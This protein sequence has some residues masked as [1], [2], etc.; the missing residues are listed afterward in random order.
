[1]ECYEGR[2]AENG[3]LD[4]DD[5]QLRTKL[6]LQNEEVRKKLAERFKY[7]MVDEYQDTNLVQYDILRPLITNYTTGNLFV[8]GDDKQSIYGFRGA[9]VEVFNR[10]RDEISGSQSDGK[11][12]LWGEEVTSDVEERRGRII[13]SESF[14]LLT[15]LVAFVNFVFKQV[16]GERISRYEVEYSPLVKARRTD[17]SGKIEM[18]LLPNDGKDPED[19]QEEM[20]ARR[21]VKLVESGQIVWKEG[22]TEDEVPQPIQF[23]DVAILL[24]KRKHL[25]SIEGAL[26]KHRIPY[27]ISGGVGFYQTQEVYDFFNYFQFLLNRHNDVA[28]AGIL[29]SPFFGISDAG[30][31][32]V[33]LVEQEDADMWSKAQHYAEKPEASTRIRFAVATLRKDLELAGRISIPSLIDRILLQTGWLGTVAGGMRGELNVANLD[34]LLDI[35]REFEGKGFNNLFDFAE[36]L[37]LLISDEEREGQATVDTSGRAV[38]IMTIHA[39][40]GLEFPVVILPY[41]EGNFRYDAAPYLDT[42]LGLGF[43]LPDPEDDTKTVRPLIAKLIKLAGKNRTEAE[44]KRVFYVGATRARDMLILAGNFDPKNSKPSYLRWTMDSL[45]LSQMP[46]T[47]KIKRES[48]TK[49]WTM[50]ETGHE[51]KEVNHA[52]EIEFI[53]SSADIEI[54]DKDIFPKKAPAN[55]DNILL[56]RFKSH[57]YNEFFSATQIQTYKQC[58]TKYYLRYRLGMPE[59]IGVEEFDEESEDSDMILGQLVGKMTHE[60]FQ[61]VDPIWQ[62]EEKIKEQLDTILVRNGVIDPDKITGYKAQVFE[63]VEKYIGS[64]FGKRIHS[65]NEF[66]CEQSIIATFDDE[67]LT[68]TIDRTFRNEGGHWERLDYKTD[69]IDGRNLSDYA[70]YYEHQMAFYALLIKRSF[71]VQPSVTATLFFTKHPDNPQTS[72]FGGEVLGR[73]EEEIRESIRG[74]RQKVDNVSEPLPTQTPQCHRCAYFVGGSCLMK[75]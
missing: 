13:L 52:F 70:G 5:L 15:D 29:R 63:N 27:I 8:V 19:T 24:R 62:E 57:A 45:G 61:I 75:R 47:K 60:L 2:K 26:L 38:Q 18:L 49:I 11:P 54:E 34:K 7:I 4:F 59:A 32:E 25:P 20:I 50:T 40:K 64:E 12:F 17:A 16:M 23:G 46:V 69:E 22:G 36:R 30:L 41:L 35:A 28:L 51:L 31:Y 9:E 72:H 1:M 56:D 14:R 21:I 71:P 42:E 43:E 53:T 68:G 55:F 65:L 67:F 39:A 6:L 44:E 48:P 58:P 10:T 33:A 3:Q 73:I 66:F 37:E 74:I